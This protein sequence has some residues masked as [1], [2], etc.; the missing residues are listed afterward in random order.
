MAKVQRGLGILLALAV[1]VSR[2]AHAGDGAIDWR[3]LRA[4][5]IELTFPRTHEAFARRVLA[6][7]QDARQALGEILPA[8]DVTLQLT[9]DDFVDTAN[10]YASVLPFD[11]VHL[12]AYPPGPDSELGDHGDWLRALVFHEYSHI[13]HMGDVEGPPT[14]INAVLGRTLMPNSGLPRFFT[15]GLATWAET[16]LT[17]GDHAVEGHGGRVDS[18]AFMGEL[19]AQVLDGHLPELSELTGVPLRWPRGQGW[20]LFGSLLLDDLAQTH[21]HAS[22]RRFIDG[23]APRL[24][25]LG[26]QGTARYTWDKSLTRAWHDAV[27]RLQL[28]VRAKWRAR[29]GVDLPDPATAA[30]EAYVR[31]HDG[32][33]LTRDGEFRGRMRSWPDGQ[34][35]VVAHQASDAQLYTIE[36]ISVDGRVTK[37]HT[38]RGDC[39]EVMV[40]PDARWLLY[41]E[42]RP[43]RRLYQFRELV[44]VPLSA[45]GQVAGSELQLTHGARLRAPAV[46]PDGQTLVAVRVAQGRTDIETLPLL[47]AL[48]AAQTGREPPAWV[49]RVPAPPLG[50]TLDS[51]LPLPD[52]HLLWTAWLGAHRGLESDGS[53]LVPSALEPEWVGDLA[54]QPDGTVTA[55]VEVDGFR[56]A[57]ELGPDGWLL[58]TRTLTGVT[59]TAQIGASP[60]QLATVRRGARGLDVFLVGDARSPMPAEG[61]PHHADLPY[62]ATPTAAT[63][64]W[65]NPL[66]SIWPRAWRP[67]LTATGDRDTSAPGGIWLGAQLAGSD[68]LGYWNWLATG[69]IRDD[70][71]DPI[72]AFSLAIT[73]W[74]PT[75]T[76]DTGYQQGLSYLRRGFSWAATP[77]DRWGLGV[78][79]SWT[80]PGVRSGWTFD[81]GWRMVHSSLRDDRYA[82]RYPYD[83][84]G[85]PPIEP[86]TGIDS[87]LDGGVAWAWGANSPDASTTER[88]HAFAV[89]GSVSD[90]YTGGARRRIILQALAANRWPL[91]G[92]FIAEITSNIAA[93][94]VSGDTS[95]SF[96]V[97]G[98]QPLPTSVLAGSGTSAITVRGTPFASILR[99]GD[100]MAWGTAQVHIPL[101]DI[102]RGFD[103]LPIFVGRVR[104][105]PFV[106]GAWAFLP[107]KYMERYAGGTWST[108]AELLVNW[109][110]GYG[111]PGTLR[112]GAGHE[113]LMQSTAWWLLLGI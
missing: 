111:L 86:W 36:R 5:G 35:A 17:G 106:D 61:A 87:F 75:W 90:S 103:T 33:Q 9:L 70:G 51:P 7:W 46:S 65:Y 19:R 37:L 22:I 113:F 112:L 48:A 43:F 31:Q 95:P 108:G 10:G 16:R 24:F 29:G 54:R 45:D 3:T 81:G 13:L 47:A 50:Q 74:E 20:Y 91:G 58:A 39:D 40:T 107:P 73:R 105:T 26:I 80:L 30:F 23:I 14:W 11:L 110:A 66:R 27:A 59:S 32:T 64:G 53:A 18:P 57:A 83:P 104:V 1:V 89:R 52:G 68:A 99:A 94:P 44:A 55:V 88:L 82:I 41:T 62:V 92:H 49:L 28:R 56:E 67:L 12:Y 6:T 79:G 93:I 34:S 84:G 98:I 38:C 102:G 78:D 85:P 77:T 60:R 8:R 63:E 76:L 96:A 97:R 15:E 21:G 25:G 109:E 100:G 72:G 101:F 69:Q 71:T 2:P 42:T 4:P